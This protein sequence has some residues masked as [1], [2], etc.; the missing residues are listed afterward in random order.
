MGP[1]QPPTLPNGKD[2][3]ADDPCHGSASYYITTPN[4]VSYGANTSLTVHWF[5]DM[6]SEITVTAKIVDTGNNSNVLVSASKVFQY[7]SIGI[8]TL[9]A[10]KNNL[11]SNFYTLIVNGLVQ[12]T[13]V[14][15]ESAM[16]YVDLKSMSVLIQTDK[17][18]YTAGE[19]VKIRIISVNLDLKP[20][21]GNVD[22]VITDPGNNTVQLSL[23]MKSDLGVVS[24]EFSL[25]K[26][27]MLGI[28]N[29]QATCDGFMRN[30]YFSVADYVSPKF[31]VTLDVPLFYI[32][33]K[34]LNLTGTVKA[35][36]FYGRPI[37]GT[38][39]VS[40]KLQFYREV[41]TEIS[42]TYQISG[43]IN[44]SFTHA[45]IQNILYWQYLEITASVAEEVTGIV[46]S[47]SSRVQNV[48]SEYNLIQVGQPNGFVPGRNFTFKV[49]IQRI[50]NKNLTKEE[51]SKIVSVKI[52]PE[53]IG[54][55]HGN[56][57][58]QNYT[59]PESA[60]IDV[61]F[62]VS[63]SPQY[64]IVWVDYEN[65][66]MF[67]FF[68]KSYGRNPSIQLQ[69]AE[70]DV[71]VGTPFNLEIKTLPVVQD[72]Y[73]VVIANRKIV[74]AGKNKTTFSLIPDSSWTPAAQIMVYSLNINSTLGNIMQDIS[75]VF[76]VKTAYGNE[77]TLSWSKNR[78]EPS[79]NV[80][81]S[82]SVKESRSL[83]GLQVVDISSMLLGDRNDINMCKITDEVYAQ[84]Q[85]SLVRLT[86]A[87]VY[88]WNVYKAAFSENIPQQDNTPIFP[89]TW[90]WL[91]T[92]ISSSLTTKLQLSAPNKNTTWVATGFVISE[93]L[94]L[95]VIN[96]PVE[97]SV[98]KPLL[99]ILHAPFSLTRGEQ[100]ILEVILFNSL[101]ENLQV[102]VTLESS[103]AFDIL[104]PNNGASTVPGQ[105]NVTAQSEVGASLMFPINP[106]KLGDATV[107]VTVTSK[108]SSEVLT[109]TITVKAE[110]VKYFYS[111]SSLFDLTG[112]APQSVSRNFSFTF[113]S[114]VIPDTIEGFVTVFGDLL[115]PSVSGLESLIQIPY[116]CGEQNMINFA[117][118]IYIL[119]YLIATKQI[120]SDIKEK[121]ISYMMQGYQRELTYKRNDGSFSAFGDSDN[122]GSTWLTAF[123]FR[124]F[125][126]ARPFMNINSDI[127]DQAVAW[128]LQYQDINTGI[129]SEPGRVLHKDLQ[130]GLNGPITLTA[131]IVT[132]LLEDGSYRQ[133]YEPR[134]QKAVQYLEGKYGEGIT[135][136]YTLSVVA[137]AL[138]LANSSK[139][140]AALN[141][142]DSR[143]TITGSAKYWSTPFP[144]L[145]YYWQP[146][147]SDIETAAYALLS[148]Y[149]Q[150]RITAGIL[151]MKWLS[152][153]RN[154]NGG[155]VSTQD[156]VMAL[157]ALSKFV[158][159]VNFT[160][161]T[162]LTLTLTGSGSFVPKTFQISSNGN[163][164][165]LQR[166]Q[167]EVPQPL[168]L[169]ATATGR[170]LAIVQLNLAYNRKT[171]SRA[172][173]DSSVPEAFTLD[174]T[175][176]ENTSNFQKLSVNVCASYQGIDNKTGM[177][178]LDVGFLSGFELRPI[179]IPTTD[180]IKLVEPKEDKVYLYLDSVSTEKICIPVPLVRLANV[181]GSQDAVVTIYEYYNPR[182]TAT[183]TYN[184][185]TMKKISYCDFCGLNC[186]RCTSNVPV[187][188]QTNSSTKPGF[189]F[190]FLCTIFIAYLLLSL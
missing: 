63:Q 39:T 19:S 170:G 47:K 72:I 66:T 135:S 84:N 30:V 150:G 120:N 145:N 48:N 12:N 154:F 167:I 20:H 75:Q 157:Q 67:F 181:A 13:S 147:T 16:I 122:S 172:K 62:P 14:F 173:R 7:D 187:K 71:K 155:Y 114:D 51:R 56:E 60:I 149:Q 143:A 152:Q 189:Y 68:D 91:D 148:Y 3:S 81:L 50:D 10:V 88:N 132:S 76:P 134:V 73:Y 77:V 144:Q 140:G 22:L 101:K 45:E 92:N 138:S 158:S 109:K 95:G 36:Y 106:K 137:Y 116:G 64:I 171:S 59:I 179:G 103:T 26:S 186:T 97:L 9:P 2:G 108:V 89:E 130:G 156:T 131:Y 190:L 161:A 93:A 112:N 46:V 82:I 169:D 34:K 119:L 184:S 42:K 79:E 176:T 115:A 83:V 55:I 175:V 133:R 37:N 123:V 121:A 49:L 65:A 124:C 104:V 159:A 33:P 102:V 78:V 17:P 8:L 90:I 153:Q 27:P 24:T 174:V 178:I 146:R 183:R 164:I 54:G 163:L 38:V 182:N 57:T 129:F 15:S 168:L 107:K 40:L 32:H 111:Q 98:I 1:G 125:L 113:P 18:V 21:K 162:S 87:I 142:L 28:W 128:L 25:S 58:L 126:Q 6:Y 44:F 85:I 165:E 185:L 4:T 160:G 23:G 118:N 180:I 117:P 43:S 41:L 5:G 53:L 96:T 86:N 141:E 177:V 99:S 70:T 166:Q 80:S 110:G 136:N 29:I 127:L 52:T 151:V 35:K 100:C 105:Y 61:V 94:G 188:P 31:D 69:I 139:A 74:S 11:A